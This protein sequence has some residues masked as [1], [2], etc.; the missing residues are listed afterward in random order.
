[1]AHYEARI[2]ELEDKLARVEIV[3]ASKFSGDTI[4]SARSD[5]FIEPLNFSLEL[6]PGGLADAYNEA[7]L[8]FQLADRSGKI[9]CVWQRRRR[10]LNDRQSL[11]IEKSVLPILFLR[12]HDCARNGTIVSTLLDGRAQ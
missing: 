10:S 7:R 6:L 1:V 4:L 8:V 3:D 2:A 9:N 5:Q 11:F 12:L